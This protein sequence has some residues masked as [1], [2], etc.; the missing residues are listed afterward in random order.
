MRDAVVAVAA[1]EIFHYYDDFGGAVENC[2]GLWMEVKGRQGA[3]WPEKT[4][5]Q[6]E[7]EERKLL[8][9]VQK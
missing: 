2:E 7:E 3:A 5:V 8:N 6:K 4:H 9:I 1:A